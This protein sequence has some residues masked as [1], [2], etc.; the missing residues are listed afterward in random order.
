VM[1]RDLDSRIVLWSRGAE[2]IYGYTKEEALGRNSHELLQ[3]EF[4]VDRLCRRDRG[5]R[6]LYARAAIGRT[7]EQFGRFEQGLARPFLFPEM[8]CAGGFLAHPTPPP[9]FFN[10]SF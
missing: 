2:K 10:F 4:P 5:E 7:E 1:V 6:D 9:L 3:T 8:G